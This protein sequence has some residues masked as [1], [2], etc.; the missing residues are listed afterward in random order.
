MPP[1]RK[2]DPSGSVAGPKLLVVEDDADTRRAQVATF[3]G[4]GFEVKAAGDVPSAM[5]HAAAHMDVVLTDWRLGE[6][7]GIQL[8][9][10][11]KSRDPA[12]EIVLTSGAAG[13]SVAVDAIRLGAFDFLAKPF[14]VEAM[15]RCVVRATSAARAN[16]HRLEG[17]KPVTKPAPAEFARKPSI[18]IGSSKEGLHG[19]NALQN[20]LYPVGETTVWDQGL[21]Q[22]SQSSLSSLVRMLRHFQFAVFLL[23]PDD[24]AVIRHRRSA[25]ARDNLIFELGLFMGRLGPERV[26]FVVPDQAQDFR[27]PTDLLGITYA[28]YDAQRLDGNLRAAFGPAANAIANAIAQV[29]FPVKDSVFYAG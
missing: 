13:I 23:T 2:R 10:L 24:V 12:T 8:L 3:R 26:Y 22:L 21:F 7:S 25:V 16:R 27:L 1:E 9:E 6:L 14:T 11:W 17:T 4:L 5:Q 20:A 15:I 28:T 19:A 29:Q 18:F